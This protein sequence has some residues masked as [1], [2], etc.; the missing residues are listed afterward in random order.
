MSIFRYL[1]NLF[2]HAFVMSLDSCRIQRPQKKEKKIGWRTSHR[3]FEKGSF[4]VQTW[5]CPNVCLADGLHGSCV[6]E[7]PVARPKV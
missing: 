1:L 5:T 2:T 7:L 3:A 4:Y 6:I